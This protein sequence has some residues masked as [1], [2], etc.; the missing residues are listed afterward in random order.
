[1]GATTARDFKEQVDMGAVKMEHALEYHLL[2][3]C[4]PS[5]PLTFIPL[6]VEAIKNANAGEWDKEVSLPAPLLYKGDTLAP[7]SEIIELC[8]IECF[9]DNN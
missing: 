7:T 8:R 2:Y 1:M 9:L 6:C 4:V 3:N 5:L